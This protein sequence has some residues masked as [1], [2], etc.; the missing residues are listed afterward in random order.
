MRGREMNLSIHNLGI[1]LGMIFGLYMMGCA[2]LSYFMSIGTPVVLM[3]GSLYVG[4]AATIVGGLIGFL[5]GFVHGYIFGALIVL[6]SNA[7]SRM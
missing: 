3:L 7:L 1:T 2:Y 5:W 4:Y 6:I